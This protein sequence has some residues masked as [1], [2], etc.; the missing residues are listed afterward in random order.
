M[1]QGTGVR[2]KHNLGP[3]GLGLERGDP[4]PL[5]LLL[6]PPFQT[7]IPSQYWYY[8][9]ELSFY[10]SLLFSIASDVK[11]KVSPWAEPLSLKPTW[12]SVMNSLPYDV[13]AL[14][15]ELWAIGNR[16]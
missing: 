16:K 12:R 9:I 4:G 7:T 11:R 5:V 6:S 14:W 2:A 15:M 8:M 10:W 1:A 3:E 13:W